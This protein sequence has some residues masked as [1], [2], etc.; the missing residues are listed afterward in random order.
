LFFNLRKKNNTSNSAYFRSTAKSNVIRYCERQSQLANKSFHIID[1]DAL[2][3]LWQYMALLVKTNGVIDVRIDIPKILWSSSNT[4]PIIDES[5][6]S[7][8]NSAL[9]S[10]TTLENSLRE[11]LALG[12]I[13]TSIKFAC[14]NQLHT[15]ALIISNLDN[16]DVLKTFY[17]LGAGSIPS[18]VTV[19]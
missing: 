19:C 15:H 13:D 9:L 6:S 1:R 12:E 17:E 8:T 11:F 4:T 16:G 2:S 7:S 10:S 3:I 14:E 5:I 18:V